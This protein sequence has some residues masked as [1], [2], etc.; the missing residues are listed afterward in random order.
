MQLLPVAVTGVGGVSDGFCVLQRV[1]VRVSGG[2]RKLYGVGQFSFSACRATLATY[3]K[4]LQPR[5]DFHGKVRRLAFAA[6]STQSRQDMKQ[7]AWMP[8]SAPCFDT[9]CKRCRDGTPTEHPAYSVTCLS[10]GPLHGCVGLLNWTS[11]NNGRSATPGPRV[12]AVRLRIT[13]SKSWGMPFTRGIWQLTALSTQAVLL[14]RPGLS[15]V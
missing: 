4:R 12:P 2:G 10:R 6:A 3:T 11:I 5:A 14:S 15:A 7:A 13:L 8:E 1:S 9:G